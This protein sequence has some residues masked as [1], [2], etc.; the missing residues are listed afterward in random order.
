MKKIINQL[1]IIFSMFSAIAYSADNNSG[2]PCYDV[3]IQIDQNNRSNVKQD[4]GINVSRTAQAG[5]NNNANTAQR[6]NVNN[7]EVRQYEF[8]AA[9][10]RH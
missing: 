7:N 4:C 2:R 10:R 8:N 5:Q 1:I 3:N 9:S 6:G